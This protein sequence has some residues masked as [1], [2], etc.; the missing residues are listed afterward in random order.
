VVTNSVFLF[1]LAC[2]HAVP[3]LH[4]FVIRIFVKVTKILNDCP[5]LSSKTGGTSIIRKKQKEFTCLS[6]LMKNSLMLSW[7]SN[8]ES[9]TP[10]FPTLQRC[11]SFLTTWTYVITVGLYTLKHEKASCRQWQLLSGSWLQVLYV[12]IHICYSYGE[13][14]VLPV[15]NFERD[16]FHKTALNPFRIQ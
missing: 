9:S 14:R 7:D 12:P 1:I 10:C 11:Q 15:L 3:E 6:C 8:P 2:D 16:R 5:A 4:A 13:P